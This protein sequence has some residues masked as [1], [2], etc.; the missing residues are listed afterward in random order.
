MLA[1]KF[2]RYGNQY[3]IFS[4]FQGLNDDSIARFLGTADAIDRISNVT[5]RANALGIFQSN[6]GLWQILARQGQIPAANLNESW[7]GVIGPFAAGIGSSAQL[8]DSAQT[9][10]R[11]LWRSAGGR[12]NLSQD[13]VIALLAG[14]NQPQPDGQKVRQ[15]LAD[16]MRAVLD[17]QRLVSLDTLL[18]LGEGL[19]ELAQGKDVGETLIP[20]AGQLREFEMP[21]PM[22]TSSE[23]SEWAAGFYNTRHS[24]LQTRTDL[25]KLIKSQ[26]S[27]GPG[28]RARSGRTFPARHAGGS[29]LRLLRAARSSNSSQQSSVRTL[30]R[31]FRRNGDWRRTVLAGASR[32]RF[33]PACGR[34]RSPGGFAGGSALCSG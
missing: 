15:E 21:R 33:R 11:E 12:P 1:E 5:L 25:A 26:F 17:G 9:S 29:E 13:E 14:P 2:S 3:L 16:R 10:V 30:S 4:E 28:G 27:Q 31:F 34:R 19:N 6:V 24:S 23:R 7:Q 8:F 20:L 18:A 32:I 22:F